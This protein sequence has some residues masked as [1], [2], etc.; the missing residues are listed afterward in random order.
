MTA[1]ASGR[2]IGSPFVTALLDRAYGALAG[3]AVGDALG[4]PTQSYTRGQVRDRFGRLTGL[5]DAPDDQPVAPGMAAGRVTDD[6]E[7]ALLLAGELLATGGRLD[8]RRWADALAHWQRGLQARGSRDLLGPSTSRAIEAI[9]RGVDP[10]EAGSTGTTN[11]AAMRIAAVAVVAPWGRTDAEHEAFV[12]RVQEAC[13][14]THHTSLAIAGAAAVGAVISGALDDATAAADGVGDAGDGVGSALDEAPRPSADQRN[15][16]QIVRSCVGAR[17][18]ER[19]GTP[20][21]GP[22]IAARIRWATT[23]AASMGKAEVDEWIYDVV[24]T[25]VATQESVPAAFALLGPALQDPRRTLLRAASLGGDTDT[26]GAM[27][28]AMTGAVLGH[29]GLPQDWCERVE[30]VNDLHLEPLAA[31]LLELRGRR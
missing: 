25:T 5:L 24:G 8:A 14:P 31:R 12:D 15:C 10:A 4:M 27:L 22:S 3:L 11:G 29:R 19:R 17:L 23:T 6:T 30:R 7:Q 13:L 16:T 21:P 1:A 26:I 9:Q 2:R 20:V 28:G 18:G